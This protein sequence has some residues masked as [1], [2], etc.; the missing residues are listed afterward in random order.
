MYSCAIWK[1]NE[2]KA[3]KADILAT[4]AS[5]FCEQHKLAHFATEVCKYQQNFDTLK[6]GTSMQGGD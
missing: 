2:Y 4:N 3:Q 6:H 5:R 1:R